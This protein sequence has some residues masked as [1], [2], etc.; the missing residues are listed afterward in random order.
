MR[1][2]AHNHLP[3]HTIVPETGNEFVASQMPYAA[4]NSGPFLC[5][6]N[7]HACVVRAEGDTRLT[8]KR[9]D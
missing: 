7:V 3:D 6:T 4:R 5:A 9:D 8:V 1:G 2:N